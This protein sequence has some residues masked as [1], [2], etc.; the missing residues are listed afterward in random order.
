VRPR[1][2]VASV[3]LIA[4]LVTVAV[5]GSV[6]SRGP[7]PATSL[8]PDLFHRVEVA[9]LARGTAMTI[10]PQD[11]GDR[12]AGSLDETTALVD[13][14]LRAAPPQAPVR[15]AQKRPTAGTV[16][17]NVWRHD[18]NIS[19][20]GPGLYGNGTA[21]GQKLTKDLVGV[22]HRTL[23]CGTLVTF[24]YQ[25]VTLT[26]PVIDRGPYVSGRT[27]DLSHG[28]CAKLHHCFTGAIEWKFPG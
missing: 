3:A 24:R 7:S 5:P 25:G 20:Y 23:P 13:T 26:V 6:G 21:C 9:A 18:P 27:W 2:V 10:L 28:A 12:S 1:N 19:W 17:K 4:L 16:S 8:D 22:A 15:P 11:P 14:A